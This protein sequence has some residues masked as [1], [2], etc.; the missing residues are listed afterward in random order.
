MSFNPEMTAG[1]EI[2]KETPSLSAHTGTIAEQAQRTT[3]T[4]S[5]V[6]TIARNAMT[7]HCH[8]KV[9]WMSPTVLLAN[10]QWLVVPLTVTGP[11]FQVLG[12]KCTQHTDCMRHM[13]AS[14]LRGGP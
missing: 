1:W 9:L 13:A 2:G 3:A 12:T 8:A 11:D 4:V 5:L 7:W 6:T 10:A 14:Y